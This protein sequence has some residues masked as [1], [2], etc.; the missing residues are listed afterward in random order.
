MERVK[1][2]ELKNCVGK[3]VLIAGWVDTRRDHG[4]L[5]FVDLRD[6]TGLVQAVVAPRNPEALKKAEA[7]RGEWVIEGKERCESRVPP[8]GAPIGE[9]D[10]PEVSDH[11]RT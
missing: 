2:G 8:G 11:H 9:T 1:I 6:K 3:E 10:G 4:K 7:I 5:V